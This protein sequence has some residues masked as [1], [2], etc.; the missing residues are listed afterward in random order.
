[1]ILVTKNG[2]P[3]VDETLEGVLE[4]KVDRPFEVVVVDSGSEDGTVG[5]ARKL[6]ATVIQI[7]PEQFGHGRTRNLG[8]ELAR[9]DIL[10]FLNQ[11]A[12]PANDFWLQRLVDVLDRYP[13]VAGVHSRELPRDDCDPLRARELREG[14]LGGASDTRLV[15]LEGIDS[16]DRMSVRDRRQALAFGTVSCSI[17]RSVWAQHP[18]RDVTYAEDLFW[19]REVLEAGYWLAYEP[20]S[21][22]LHSH[23]L[24]GSLRATLRR[25]MK[26]GAARRA[27]LLSGGGRPPILQALQYVLVSTWRDWT[28]VIGLRR[29]LS[30][31]LKWLLRS[32][33]VR[34]V[35]VLAQGLGAFG[36]SNKLLSKV[37][38]KPA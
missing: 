3:Y 23:N 25:Q 12:T 7:P 27:V 11:D 10:V 6:G 19:A 15:R 26:D 14:F 1:M 34:G 4:Q 29:P 32:P 21:M 13:D 24:Y 28:Y 18:F 2:R 30:Y 33:L 35:Q 17:R 5:V 37:R 36:G 16:L 22:V 20:R 9:G 31:R 38:Q 8:A